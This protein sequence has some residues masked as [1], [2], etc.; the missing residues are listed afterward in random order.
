MKKQY[1]L[2]KLFAGLILFLFTTYQVQAAD[3]YSRTDG[4]FGDV[5]T[6]SDIAIGGASCGCTPSSSDNVF[7]GG[8]NTVTVT[9]NITVRDIT[10]EST[11]TLVLNANLTSEDGSLIVNGTFTPNTSTFTL[12]T[13]VGGS[14]I[15]GSANP[16]NFY[17][18]QTGGNS[19]GVTKIA[20]NLSIANNFVVRG[21][22]NPGPAMSFAENAASDL[23]VTVS[24]NFTISDDGSNCRFIQGADNPTL[25]KSNL[26]RIIASRFLP[27]DDYNFVY[28]NS[29]FTN[30]VDIEVTGSN[31]QAWNN[32]VSANPAATQFHS[33]I[34]SGSG[35]ITANGSAYVA[36]DITVTN[37]SAAVEFTNS[38]INFN[39]GADFAPQNMGNA[40]VSLV[41]FNAVTL[42]GQGTEV[43]LL[44]D[45]A[46][47]SN[48]NNTANDNLDNGGFT[49]ESTA[50]PVAKFL[51]NGKT[52]NLNNTMAIK[53]GGASDPLR[54]DGSGTVAVNAGTGTANVRGSFSFPTL[55]MVAGTL[56]FG[57]GSNTTINEGVEV[58]GGTVDHD[59]GGTFTFNNPGGAIIVEGLVS[60][61]NLGLPT[62]EI[63][64]G[65]IVNASKGFDV[66]GLF[67]NNGQFMASDGQVRLRNKL[68][69]GTSY[70]SNSQASADSTVFFDLILDNGNGNNQY[71]ILDFNLTALNETRVGQQFR[72]NV[73]FSINHPIF[74]STKNLFVPSNNSFRGSN[75]TLT[76][77]QN[78]YHTV[79]VTGDI[80]YD[81]A[82]LGFKYEQGGFVQAFNLLLEPQGADATYTWANSQSDFGK[83]EFGAG[84]TH[85]GTWAHP[86]GGNNGYFVDSI[87]HNAATHLFVSQHNARILVT[88]TT[89][90]LY[91]LGTGTGRLQLPRVRVDNLATV[92][93]LRDVEID[94]FNT[95]TNTNNNYTFMVRNG[96]LWNMN[97]NNLIFSNGGYL[98]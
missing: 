77:N 86:F 13:N 34:F 85:N 41:T 40:S 88:S 25:T 72:N 9:A 96:G 59:N 71:R 61:G 56:S 62:V 14:Q 10:V 76:L 67:N 69:N 54:F 94:G 65:T 27:S 95:G 17:N 68:G 45:I 16:I 22:G 12:S 3:L 44:S 83:I 30:N 36:K 53:D 4:N 28:S 47:T 38:R 79:R 81:G 93:Q 6:W 19:A 49:F 50:S 90:P 29:G 8:S 51:M 5:G 60:S 2:Q 92:E 57:G 64:D 55:K 20:Q 35:T 37:A 75:G 73:N 43:Q 46:V 89:V 82:S 24:E 78:L 21:G 66:F 48:A 33:L 1:Y 32:T 91:I 97:G 18:L 58:E 84:A 80:T 31:I 70:G 98:R 26:H 7:I 87:V 52:I 15:A 39:G 63:T 42:W 74:F 23:T 11:G